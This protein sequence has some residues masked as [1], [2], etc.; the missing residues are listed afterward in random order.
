VSSVVH[1]PLLPKFFADQSDNIPMGMGQNLMKS[2]TFQR[3]VKR[4]AASEFNRR[5]MEIVFPGQAIRRLKKGQY[6]RK[7]SEKV[8]AVVLV[9]ILL[10]LC[11]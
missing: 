10:M 6:G 5:D 7:G 3:I 2:M 4:R 8:Q 9:S 1:N 11:H